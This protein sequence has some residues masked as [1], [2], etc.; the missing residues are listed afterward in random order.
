MR[1]L[2]SGVTRACTIIEILD[3]I[4]QDGGASA[5]IFK[6]TGLPPGLLED[7]RS[8][9]LLKDQFALLD[10]AAREVGDDTFAARLSLKAGI[11]GLGAYGTVVASKPTLGEALVVGRAML[12]VAMQTATRLNL[13]VDG[14]RTYWSYE[15]DEPAAVGRSQNEILA[16]GY[17][18]NIFRRFCGREWVPHRLSTVVE[19]DQDLGRIGQVFACE[20]SRGGLTEFEFPTE[21]LECCNRAPLPSNPLDHLPDVDGLPALVRL[22]I[23]SGLGDHPPSLA[24]TAHRLGLSRRTLQRRLY[25]HGQ[26][27]ARLRDSTLKSCALDLIADATPIT[28]IAY[29]LGFADPSQLSRAFRRWTGEAPSAWRQR[30][31]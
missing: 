22:A 9:I 19:P 28:E 8:V 18:L 23:I 30:L 14:P 2:I 7:P 31:M 21:L 13:R 16:I 6:R 26:S 3:A 29:R 1:L 4:D 12:P 5:R 15:L 25:E 27:F 11:D 24:R 20:I 10:A 17:T